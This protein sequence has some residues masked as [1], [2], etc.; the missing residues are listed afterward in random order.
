MLAENLTFL[1][2]SLSFRDA[3]ILSTAFISVAMLS[4]ESKR[5][6]CQI[7]YVIV[8][9]LY[10]LSNLVSER[11]SS[12]I[13]R[14]EIAIIKP[15]DMLAISTW[16]LW[17]LSILLNAISKSHNLIVGIRTSTSKGY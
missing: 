10:S 7:E 16:A 17:E 2:S 9:Y 15:S 14:D 5:E 12:V 6:P 8:I 13:S 3:M 11:A 1:P 4:I